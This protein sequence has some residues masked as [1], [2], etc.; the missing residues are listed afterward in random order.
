ME[1]A[2]NL[3]PQTPPMRQRNDLIEP[4]SNQV[5]I[6]KLRLKFS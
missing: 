4:C 6:L 3:T 5:M 2:G 1:A